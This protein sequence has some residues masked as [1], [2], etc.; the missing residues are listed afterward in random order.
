MVQ[1]LSA[2]TDSTELRLRSEMML[3]MAGAFAR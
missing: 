2:I 1:P 3:R